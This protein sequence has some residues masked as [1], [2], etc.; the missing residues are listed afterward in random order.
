MV[1]QLHPQAYRFAGGDVVKLE[2]LPSDAPYA[3]PSNLQAPI[4][5]SNLELR[6]PVREQ[7][8]SLGGVVQPPAPKV[9]PPGY[10]LAAGYEEPGA[11][12]LK[13][14]PGSTTVHSIAAT[15]RALLVRLRCDS[16]G[17]CSGR[18][19]FDTRGKS[20]KRTVLA[21]GHYSLPRGKWQTLRL[22]LRKGGRKLVAAKHR[23]SHRLP[24]AVELE[25]AGRG[26]VRL[27]R[28]VR[29]RR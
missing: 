10:A 12:P 9:L 3:R 5:V 1:F 20:K 29:L 28:G 8:G 14:G 11:T 4:A 18:I 25:D 17:A 22:P 23:G 7:P 6:L 2:L 26:A 13:A 15:R 24:V 21:R 27:K 19:A 16:G